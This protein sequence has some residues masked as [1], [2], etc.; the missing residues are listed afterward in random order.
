MMLI[1][2]WSL[3]M[4]FRDTPCTLF[5]GELTPVLARRAQS[6]SADTLRPSHTSFPRKRGSTRRRRRSVRYLVVPEIPVR[7]GCRNAWQ[8]HTRYCGEG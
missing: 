5:S 1:V 2:C 6:G 3:T 8:T 4:N 7:N